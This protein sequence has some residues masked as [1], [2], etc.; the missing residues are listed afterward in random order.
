MD[1]TE[2]VSLI[3]KDI[4]NKAE[5]IVGNNLEQIILYGSVARGEQD[6]ESDLDI[7]LLVNGDDESIKK[8]D[9]RFSLLM[10]ELSLKYDMLVSI[11]LLNIRQFEKFLEVLPFYTN[12]N[13]EGIRIYERRVA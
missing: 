9:D 7:M 6:S 8:W 11:M 10:F 5:E 3:S 13:R 2:K 4:K 1:L 12:V